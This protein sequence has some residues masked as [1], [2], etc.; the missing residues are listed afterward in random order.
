MDKFSKIKSEILSLISSLEKELAS[1]GLLLGTVSNDVLSARGELATI[2]LKKSEI[3]K[4]IDSRITTIRAR[5]NALEIGEQKLSI[6]TRDSYSKMVALEER[7]VSLASS[8]AKLEDKSAELESKV[9]DYSRAK[10]L[11]DSVMSDLAQ[12]NKD[13]RTARESL[14]D[15]QKE[16]EDVIAEIR[17][18][19][20]E[21]EDMVSSAE[22]E[23]EQILA[24]NA[25]IIKSLETR[26]IDVKAKEKD[27]GVVIGRLREKANELGVSF[28]I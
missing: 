22:K 16:Q 19:E 20:K 1:T 3:E 26:E 21:S 8:I 18:A 28:R 17:D 27:I 24:K 4:D 2:I 23:R 11:Y 12:A 14:A 6:K 7:M 10:S 9:K 25:D 15:Y 5:E 13:L